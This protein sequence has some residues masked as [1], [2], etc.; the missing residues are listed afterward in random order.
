MEHPHVLAGEV[1]IPDAAEWASCMADANSRNVASLDVLALD[2]ERQWDER[3]HNA[4]VQLR[5]KDVVAPTSGPVECFLY[6]RAEQAPNPES[7]VV[8]GERTDRY[9]VPWPVLH[10]RL[11]GRDW[12]SEKSG[13]TPSR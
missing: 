11:A 2:D 1:E 5:P 3:L 8:L 10:W 12:N 9:G 7:R 6:V 13:L 4:T